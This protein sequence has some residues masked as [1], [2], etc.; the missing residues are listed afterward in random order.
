MTLLPA[1]G[2]LLSVSWLA[3]Q[4]VPRGCPR[5]VTVQRLCPAPGGGP[6]GNR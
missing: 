3:S 2:Q 4:R 1:S 6:E 5:R